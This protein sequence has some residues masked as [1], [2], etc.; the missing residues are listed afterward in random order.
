MSKKY[1]ETDV[2]GSLSISQNNP[3][4]FSHRCDT[5]TE[6]GIICVDRFNVPDRCIPPRN[7]EAYIAPSSGEE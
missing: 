2:C 5:K 4:W 3:T 7:I 6:N 1:F